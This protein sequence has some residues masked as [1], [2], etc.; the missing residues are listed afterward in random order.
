[1]SAMS[2]EPL[3]PPEPEPAS[4]EFRLKPTDFERVNRPV[5]ESGPG[6]APID[7][8]QLYRQANLPPP[9]PTPGAAPPRENDVHA[10][11]RDN[12]AREKAQ[13][14]NAVVPQRRP[15]SRRTRDFWVLF[16]GGNSLVVGMVA[17]LHKNPVTLVF[18]FSA[19]V[20]FSLGLIWVM[21]MVM[22][23]Y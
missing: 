16:V 9:P 21:W 22:D 2:D 3:G 19:I 20:F 12:V 17:L 10:I 11:L 8:Q 23:D 13:G 1:M 4:R 7:V 6:N 15:V 18:G 5:N 14:L